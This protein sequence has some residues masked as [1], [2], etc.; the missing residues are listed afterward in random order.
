MLRRLEERLAG[1]PGVEA[2]V[3]QHDRDGYVQVA[4]HPSDRVGGLEYQETFWVRT[5]AAPPGFFSLMGFPFVRGRGFDRANQDDDRALVIRGDLA[6]RLWGSADPIGRRLVHA[7]AGQEATAFVIVGVVDETIAGLSGDG[8]PHV[9]VPNLSRTGSILVRTRGPAEPVAP[10]I[11]SVANAEAPLLP[12]TRATTLA[13]IDAGQRSV[14]RRA[15]TGAAGGG[16]V[17]LFLCAIGLYAVV[18]FAVGQRTREIGIRTALGADP[19]Q[20]VRMFF[21]R[22]LRLSFVGLLIGLTLSMIVLRLIALSQ[23]RNTEAS[24]VVIAVLIAAV[25]IAVAS[26]AIWIPAR[27]AASVDP[28]TMLRTE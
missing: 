3:P 7:A 23:G 10:L 12:V 15:I 4:V 22:G 1:L 21:F 28:L 17:A 24:I 13:A 16:L 9:F 14:F 18:S 19:R 20:V 8:E 11:R 25:V 27:R 2:V 6:R 26:L 5:R